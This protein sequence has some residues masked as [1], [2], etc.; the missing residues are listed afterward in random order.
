MV[1]VLGLSNLCRVASVASCVLFAIK[2]RSSSAFCLIHRWSA[3]RSKVGD[4][5]TLQIYHSVSYFCSVF[6]TTKLQHLCQS[7]VFVTSLKLLK[8]TFLIC[9]I[10]GI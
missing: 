8:C 6:Q 5:T 4:Q 2:P 9:N 10:Q 1:V 7:S 3:C